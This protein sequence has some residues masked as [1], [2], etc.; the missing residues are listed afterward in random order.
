MS[1]LKALQ[2]GFPLL[3]ALVALVWLV[4]F[5]LHPGSRI[6]YE[7]V[8]IEA[9]ILAALI[10][11]FFVLRALPK[12]MFGWGIFVIP[13][14][15]DV[16]DEITSEPEFFNTT[17]EGILKVLGL[18]LILLGFI[19]THRDVE[20]K[21]EIVEKRYR[22]FSTLIE[23]APIPMIVYDE[24]G[25]VYVNRAAEEVTGY[26]R[27]E[28]L[29]GVFWELF[30]GE[31]LGKV[32]EVIAK[33][34]RGE[35]VAPY[36]LRIKRKDGTYRTLVSYG[37]H[38]SIGGRRYGV[39]AFADVSELEET[40]KRV[41]ELS[42]II[43]LIN[44]ILRHDVLNALTSAV[45]FMDLYKEEKNEDYCEKIRLSID[46]AVQILKNMR[47]FEEAVKSGELKVV[48]VREIA[49]SVVKNF[50]IPVEI[51]GEC[52]AVADEGLSTVFEN[53]IQNAIQ[54]SGTE[55]VTIK[56]KR[57]ADFCEIRVSDYG[58]GIP[59]ELKKKVFEPGF[60]YGE[61]AGSGL[62]LYFVK[63]ILERYHGKIEI[64]DNFPKGTTFVIRLRAA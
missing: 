55:K 32:R 39:A 29:G 26:S 59:D 60:S 53:L 2:L 38:V 62:G 46:R 1:N 31:E 63:R 6:D 4:S 10:A 64:E 30:E 25:F 41:K 52:N 24:K 34:L 13:W 35:E 42:E 56:I 3:W 14:I 40:I 54:H 19:L 48:N 8:A 11:A 49:E 18:I 23:V 5:P 45:A 21:R 44:R 61:K 27:S 51:D 12:V 36:K 37:T 17:L 33:R 43:S 58:K 9:S 47:S 16:L 50:A 28:L 7:D 20:E 22:F 57:T 15:T